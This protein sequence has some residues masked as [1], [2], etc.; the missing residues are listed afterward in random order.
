[1]SEA[2]TLYSKLYAEGYPPG[3]TGMLWEFLKA[4]IPDMKGLRILDAGCGPGVMVKRFMSVGCRVAGMDVAT[5]AVRQWGGPEIIQG[6]LTRLPYADNAFDLV[7]CCD[8]LEHLEPAEVPVALSEM[9]RVAPRLIASICTRESG[10]KGMK[11]LHRTVESDGWW[12]ERMIHTYQE[13]IDMWTE[14]KHW[15]LVDANLTKPNP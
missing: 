7:W 3:P 6:S 4:R 8:V 5:E 12:M 13:R 14:H 11:D 15:L 2:D 10:W 9:A 1:M